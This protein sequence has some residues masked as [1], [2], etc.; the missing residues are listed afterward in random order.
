MKMI[1]S[2]AFWR[3]SAMIAIAGALL[4]TGCKKDDNVVDDPHDHD[5]DEAELITSM[6]LEFSDTAHVK[7]N[8]TVAFRDPDGEGGNAATEFDTIK[9]AANTVYSL[10]ITL[11]DESKSPAVKISDEVKTEGDE[12]LFCFDVTSANVS[13]ARTDSDGTYEIG[14]DSRWTV[15]AASKGNVKVSLKHQPGVKNGTCNV[16][17]TDVEVNFVTEI[18]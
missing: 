8:V 6:V 18:K 1:R 10:K 11:L 7:P 9:L 12:H 17:D 5:H 16:G 3:N 13:I 14:L 2:N 15:A 4:I